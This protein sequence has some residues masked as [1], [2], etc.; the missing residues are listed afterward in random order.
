MDVSCWS[1]SLKVTSQPESLICSRHCKLCSCFHQT[2]CRTALPHFL[3]SQLALTQADISERKNNV[4][5]SL[6]GTGW[7]EKEEAKGPT[8]QTACMTESICTN[9]LISFG[10]SVGLSKSTTS[11]S[12]NCR[13]RKQEGKERKRKLHRNETPAQRRAVSYTPGKTNQPKH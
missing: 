4:K 5:G 2:P 1:L 8:L 10:G 13:I 11:A 7:K 6:G 9:S 12:N 3:L